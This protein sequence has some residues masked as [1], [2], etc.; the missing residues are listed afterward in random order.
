MSDET[1]TD[2]ELAT[3]WGVSTQALYQRR[4]KGLGPPFKKEGGVPHY[5]LATIIQWEKKGKAILP[6]RRNG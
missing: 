4:R 5:R 3:R 2:Y 1:I 6:R